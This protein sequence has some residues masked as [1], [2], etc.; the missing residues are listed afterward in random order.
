MGLPTTSVATR[1]G[2]LNNLAWSTLTAIASPASDSRGIAVKAM[3][4]AADST[5]SGRPFAIRT[6]ENAMEHTPDGHGPMKTA[7]AE[8]P[9]MG[10]M[11]LIDKRTANARRPRGRGARHGPLRTLRRHF[12]GA[13]KVRTRNPAAAIPITPIIVAM[14]EIPD[15]RCAASGMTRERFLAGR[16]RQIDRHFHDRI[17]RAAG[18][19]PLGRPMGERKK[20]FPASRGCRNKP[21]GAC[22]FQIL[23]ASR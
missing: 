17:N 3:A 2:I 16:S 1:P 6:N 12:R 20:R 15:C 4:T 8:A 10:N 13:P 11:P 7:A 5:T 18:I 22:V 21:D 23:T 19:F 9:V 14:S